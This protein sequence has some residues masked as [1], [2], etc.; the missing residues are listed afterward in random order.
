MPK[1]QFRSLSA[2][3]WRRCNVKPPRMSQ[4]LMGVAP[5]NSV[6]AASVEAQLRKRKGLQAVNC[7]ETFREKMVQKRATGRSSR[8]VP[9]T[10]SAVLCG[11]SPASATP[12]GNKPSVRTSTQPNPHLPDRNRWWRWRRRLRSKAKPLPGSWR[13][14]WYFVR[15]I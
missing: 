11:F 2:E 6:V 9:P 3:N 13:T 14:R 12:E 1:C 8:F 4:C 5:C 7:S 10:C 15:N